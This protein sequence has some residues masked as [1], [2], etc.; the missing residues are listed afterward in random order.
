MPEP[1]ISE[2]ET[3]EQRRGSEILDDLFAVIEQRRGA[4]PAESWTAK[5]L[6]KGV[7][8]ICQKLGEEAT[9]TVVAALAETHEDLLEESADLLYHLLVLWAAKGVRPDEVY[10]VLQRRRINSDIKKKK[11]RKNQKK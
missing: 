10:E 7:A 6:D 9:E 4:D 3:A 2:S 11:Q 8:K 5:L 1:E